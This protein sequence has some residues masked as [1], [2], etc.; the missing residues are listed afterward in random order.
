[1]PLNRM[2]ST[3][4][5]YEIAAIALGA[6]TRR[7]LPDARGW[8]CNGQGDA[9]VCT[10][11]RVRDILA[12]LATGAGKTM[13]ILLAAT[14]EPK[15]ASVVILPLKSVVQ[16]YTHR[17]TRMGIPHQVWTEAAQASKPLDTSKNLIIV[18]M[19]QAR[20]DSFR[21]ALIELNRTIPVRR[22]FVDEPQYALTSSNFRSVYKNLEE[23][24]IMPAQL[25]LLSATIPPASVATIL[26]A[27]ALDSVPTIIRSSTVRP[28]IEYVVYPAMA[29][30]AIQTMVA[31]LVSTYSSQFGPDDRGII[32]VRTLSDAD[33]Y[34]ATLHLPC[35][36]GVKQGT[37]YTESKQAAMLDQWRTG[38]A[39]FIVCTTAFACGNDY[40][41]VRIS[42]EAQ[43]AHNFQDHIQQ[44]GRIGRNHVHA[45]AI[46]L[47]RINMAW[48]ELA[49]SDDVH[50]GGTALYRMIYKSE[51]TACLRQMTTEWADGVGTSCD[52][53]QNIVKCSKCS[54]VDLTSPP[55][56]RGTTHIYANR[57]IL[58]SNGNPTSTSDLSY[59][60]DFKVLCTQA[61]HAHGERNA[62]AN[63]YV[64]KLKEA[65]DR[66]LETCVACTT[67]K[68]VPMKHYRHSRDITYCQSIDVKAYINF[69]LKYAIKNLCWRC[70]VPQLSEDLHPQNY[71]DSQHGKVCIYN[72]I[73]GPVA[74][75]C[76]I[77]VEVRKAMAEAF[78]SD[79]HN[80]EE[81]REW[82]VCPFEGEHASNAVAVFMWW[83]DKEQ[84]GT[85]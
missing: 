48:P 21:R 42:I 6:M 33:Y 50:R 41:H 27:Y 3:V 5:H 13:A 64:L 7:F 46:V 36:R 44:E 8:T 17:L 83:A 73:I 59:T 61:R 11:Q 52:A 56:L 51:P 40:A 49:A 65:L 69:R 37:A 54:A 18:I 22:I 20:K 9:V 4:G 55:P 45:I 70:H 14:L 62:D 2:W 26:S 67:A 76:W 47:P 29:G 39:K 19:D 43:V 84:S 24:R 82:L 66:Y 31:Q 58:C 71:S 16:D 30:S 57:T 12:I 85:L 15:H 72:D 35:Y 75:A 63:A 38:Q 77:N 23:L 34:S 60:A 10:L 1:M 68:V 74:Y 28:E 78:E 25:V 80:L 53:D 32:W 81:Y 79:W